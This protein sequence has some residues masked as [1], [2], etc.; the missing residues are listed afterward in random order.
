LVGWLELGLGC[1]FWFS[2]WRWDKGFGVV[3]ERRPLVGVGIGMGAF[4]FGFGAGI[5]GLVW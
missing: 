3:V 4:G 5:R 1:G 2:V